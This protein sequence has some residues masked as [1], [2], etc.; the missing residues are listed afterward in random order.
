[1]DAPAEIERRLIMERT[2]KSQSHEARRGQYIR[3]IFADGTHEHWRSRRKLK[4]FI[5]FTRQ[6]HFYKH[7]SYTQ[8]YA[9]TLSKVALTWS[10][11]RFVE[12]PAGRKTTVACRR[13]YGWPMMEGGAHRRHSFVGVH[14]RVTRRLTKRRGAA[15][16][17]LAGLQQ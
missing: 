17:R 7:F 6:C 4:E 9:E 1:M 14:R 13:A 16:H 2:R 3:E 10:G 5:A 12:A 8:H 11:V 15:D